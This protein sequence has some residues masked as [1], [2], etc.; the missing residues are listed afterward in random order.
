MTVREKVFVLVAGKSRLITS[1]V[2]VA[3]LYC[4]LSMPRFS[5]R[6]KVEEETMATG[7]VDGSVTVQ[8]WIHD[9]SN[10][11]E[12]LALLGLAHF[13]LPLSENLAI[14]YTVIESKRGDTREAAVYTF[15]VSEDEAK[16]RTPGSQIG[17]TLASGLRNA[18]WLSRD[19]YILFVP[20][21]ATV[22]GFGVRAWLN[23]FYRSNASSLDAE[24]PLI[25]SA[26]AVDMTEPGGASVLIEVEGI[27]GI[28]SNQDISNILFEIERDVPGVRFTVRPV[29]DS[30][31]FSAMNGAVHS[32]HAA[33][34]DFAIPAISLRRDP[35]S[36]PS[37]PGPS[38]LY[39]AQAVGKHVR[40]LTALFH[41]FHHSTSFF[42]YTDPGKEV[43]LGFIV[44]VLVGVFSPLF[45]GLVALDANNEPLWLVNSFVITALMALLGVGGLTFASIL[46]QY[47]HFDTCASV[48]LHNATNSLD[49]L[50]IGV[51]SIACFF[52]FGIVRYI[53]NMG[54]CDAGSALKASAQ[55]VYA[56]IITMVLLFHYSGA[57][58]VTAFAVPALT[59]VTPMRGAPWIN[60][61]I[62]FSVLMILWNLFLG[63]A[64]GM[65]V[66]PLPEG[67]VRSTWGDLLQL[68]RRN[69]IGDVVPV[70]FLEFIHH[71]SSGHTSYWK[72]LAQLSQEFFCVQGLALVHFSCVIFPALL[73]STEISMSVWTSRPIA[74][75]ESSFQKNPRIRNM[76]KAIVLGGIFAAYI[77]YALVENLS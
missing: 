20:K 47:R 11:P 13:R 26:F 58:L 51:I 1:V 6:A 48:T 68:A 2:F 37:M 16:E 71:L 21:A 65:W 40:S 41:Q 75:H 4:F 17:L 42:L 9:A 14:D 72:P 55:Q 30:I 32:L 23:D 12:Q 74:V 18:M 49:M 57:V 67:I 33:F 22:F 53:A 45:P 54:K 38:P 15:V 25:R 10:V 63:L 73:L 66:I 3:C 36:D 5:N 44:P 62:S 46:F 77:A 39:I 43:S 60:K 31:A 52:H 34:Q 28:L 50:T 69:P 8:D 24:K 56:M 19:V 7:E 61:I 29:F 70:H 27:N 64:L 76:S 59:L 35:F